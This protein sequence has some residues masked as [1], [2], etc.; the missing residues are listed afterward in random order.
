MN[1]KNELWCRKT[2]CEYRMRAVHYDYSDK[3]CQ[4]S[5]MDGFIC[6]AFANE[7]VSVWMTGLPGDGYYCEMYAKREK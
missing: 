5:D 1:D 2:D 7:G 4:H 6:I 3:G